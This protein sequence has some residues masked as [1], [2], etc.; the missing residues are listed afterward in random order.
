MQVSGAG[1]Y[2]GIVVVSATRERAVRDRGE[3]DAHDRRKEVI[4]SLQH[5]RCQRGECCLR[6]L[7]C[8][9][10]SHCRD[11][12]DDRL[13]L[14]R[15]VDGDVRERAN[16]V[17]GELVVLALHVGKHERP[18]DAIVARDFSRSVPGES[19][20]GVAQQGLLRE[21]R[22]LGGQHRL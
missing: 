10:D 21:R 15:I 3:E 5:V 18:E 13:L 9:V 7:V 4:R 22:I 2:S 20:Q 19:A 12:G 11:L 6:D 1:G 14:A 8:L 16:R 17:H